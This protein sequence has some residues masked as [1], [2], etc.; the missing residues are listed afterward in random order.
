M[1][2]IFIR[3]NIAESLAQALS[4]NTL[5]IHARTRIV[6]VVD[7]IIFIYACYYYICR[8]NVQCMQGVGVDLNTI[9]W[10]HSYKMFSISIDLKG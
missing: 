6:C 2:I 3:P 8:Y 5:S 1:K 7:Q 4:L 9:F 10:G